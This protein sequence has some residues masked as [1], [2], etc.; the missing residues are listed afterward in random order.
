MTYKPFDQVEPFTS[1]YF[2][3]LEK[4]GLAEA[5][6]EQRLYNLGVGVCRNLD[7]GNTI[8]QELAGLIGDARLNDGDA[9]ALVGAAV[10][11]ICP[12]HGPA[13]EEY[14]ASH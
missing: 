9:G 4:T 8:D 6:G 10:T 12:Y 1:L 13:V 11:G 3:T 14:L 7:R 5:Q 2:I